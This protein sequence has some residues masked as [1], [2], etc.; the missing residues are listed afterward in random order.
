MTMEKF[1]QHWYNNHAP[2]VVPFFL[3]SGVQHYE[4]IHGPLITVNP[5]AV[6]GIDVQSF[7]GAAGMPPQSVMDNPAPMPKWKEEYYKEVILPDERRFLISEALN[8]ITRVGPGTIKGETKVVIG[9]GKCLIDIPNEVW[10]VWREY[11][12][13]GGD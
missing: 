6:S 11:E 13:R 2:L 5:E 3:H 10:K 9:D 12:A 8:H 4:Q 7:D 1:S